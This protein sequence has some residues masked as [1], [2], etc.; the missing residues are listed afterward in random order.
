[1]KNQ[2]ITITTDIMG[3]VV[4]HEKTGNKYLVLLEARDP[5]NEENILVTYVRANFFNILGMKILKFLLS[6]SQ[7]WVRTKRNFISVNSRG[8]PRFFL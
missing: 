1:M 6:D 3:K 5:D 8:L 2:I 7:I 4:T